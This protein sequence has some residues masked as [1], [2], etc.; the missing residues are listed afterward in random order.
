MNY[1]ASLLTGF[2]LISIALLFL[3]ASAMFTTATIMAADLAIGDVQVDKNTLKPGERI[4]LSFSLNKSAKTTVQVYTPDYNVVQRLIADQPM[5]A[6]INTVFWDGMDTSGQMVPNEAYLF[7][8]QAVDADG[9]Q[10]IYD[11][12][13]T[14]GGA[15]SDVYIHDIR[16][17]E[18]DVTITYT[19]SQPSRISLRAGIH[20]GPLLK[21]LLNWQPMPA[22]AHVY[23][24]DGLDET[25]RIRVMDQP[26]GHVYIEGFALANNAV[27]V[28]ESSDNY[29]DYQKTLPPPENELLNYQSTRRSIMQRIDEGISSQSLVRRALNVSPVFTV[30]LA[31]DTSTGLAEKPLT[32]VS[33]EI[34]LLVV[35]AP[36]SLYLFNETRHEIILFVDNQRFDEE[37]HAYTP[38]TYTLDTRRLSNGERFITVN[39]A[40]LTGQVG[41]YSFYINVNN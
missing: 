27:I 1:T 20:K 4:K 7:G 19:L 34:K 22:G 18:N 2:R 35:V 29:L 37:E 15:V 38:Y 8:I 40:S 41:S 16:K 28:Q 3:M 32:T 9:T 13:A 5:P 25:G 30:Y 10:V 31:D 11:P 6:G 21:T 14:S 26:G 17:P 36:E 23:S 33:G 12:T 39:Q 24:W